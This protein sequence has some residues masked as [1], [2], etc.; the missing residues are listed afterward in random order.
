MD[1][2]KIL[3]FLIANKES[4]LMQEQAK[5]CCGT[6]NSKKSLVYKCPKSYEL[7]VMLDEYQRRKQNVRSVKT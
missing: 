1:A 4:L 6:E 5:F 2:E 3:E 7:G